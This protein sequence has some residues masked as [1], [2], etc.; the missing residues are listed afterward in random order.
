MALARVMLY[1]FLYTCRGKGSIFSVA[2]PPKYMKRTFA[3][4]AE[5]QCL[6]AKLMHAPSPRTPTNAQA[7]P[8]WVFH[9]R[10]R[11]LAISRPLPFP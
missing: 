10:T 3:I 9:Q 4:A 7:L 1:L 5:N 11:D 6:G 2:W 8:Q